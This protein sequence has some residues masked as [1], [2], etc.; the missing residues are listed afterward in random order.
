MDWNKGI[1]YD[2]SSFVPP[3][4]A[5]TETLPPL[6][7][8]NKSVY[9]SLVYVC[10]QKNLDGR[11]PSR[12]LKISSNHGRL[13]KTDKVDVYVGCGDLHSTKVCKHTWRYVHRVISTRWT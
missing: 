6:L 2:H 12:E 11:I 4:F 10:L 13:N 3:L 1:D 8:R 9:N 5:S 7:L